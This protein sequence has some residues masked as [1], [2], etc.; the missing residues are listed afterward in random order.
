MKNKFLQFNFLLLFSSFPL[1]SSFLVVGNCKIFMN[2]HFL[3]F[4]LIIRLLKV[5]K[6][7]MIIRCHIYAPKFKAL[8]MYISEGLQQVSERLIL[9]I[10]PLA[11]SFIES[12]PHEEMK[13]YCS[14]E[15][16]W[17]LLHRLVPHLKPLL[18]SFLNISD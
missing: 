8:T 16:K 13:P 5:S 4:I 7:V 15:I 10:Y 12:L 11:W 1:L 18:Q 3:A 14:S 17:Y 2:R 6:I 9:R